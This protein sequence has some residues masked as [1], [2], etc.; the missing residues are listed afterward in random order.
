[1]AVLDSDGNIL[2][3]AAEA[4]GEENAVTIAM[5]HW[6]SN[7]ENGKTYGSMVIYVTKGND[8][9][10]LVEE[11]YF[12]LPGES[13]NTNIF[14]RCEGPVPCCKCWN[15]GHRAFACKKEQVCQAAELSCAIFG[16]PHEAF[17]R[18]CRLRRAQD[19]GY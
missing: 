1:M 15:I 11:G 19:D 12:H 5:I 18:N 6:L 3:G 2:P 13:A 9:K 14:G 7:K 4:L 16:G 10:R 8:A 17:S